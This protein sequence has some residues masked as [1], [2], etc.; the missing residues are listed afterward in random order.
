MKPY[1]RAANE[2]TLII[3][4]I[5]S[6]RAL[7]AVDAIARVPGVDV[8]MLGPGDLSVIAGIPYQFDH[9]IITGAYRA[10]SQAAKNAGKA[11]GTVSGSPEHTQMLMDLG[12]TF[13]CHGADIIM[14]KQGMERIQ[15]Q[16]AP[17]GFTFDNRLAAEAT[18]LEQRS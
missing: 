6:T 10:L 2:H 3:T 5:E 7:D 13:I 15:Q 9:P 1:L 14:V 17:L 16:Y 12:A 8:L 4:Q 18:A 11:W